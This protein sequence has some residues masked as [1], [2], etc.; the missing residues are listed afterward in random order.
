M[1]KLNDEII[2]IKERNKKVETDK[3]WETSLTRKLSILLLTYVVIAITLQILGL[4]KPF[5]GAII[6]AIAFFLSTLTIPLFK[7]WWIENIYKK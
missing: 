3:A 7:I 4:P 1:S 2:K 5:I 6:P